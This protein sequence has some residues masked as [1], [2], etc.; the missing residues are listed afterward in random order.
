VSEQLIKEYDELCRLAGARD[1][2]I[3]TE[4]APTSRK[5]ASA[6]KRLDRSRS[7]HAQNR[8]CD[9]RAARS[10]TGLLA[11]RLPR[12]GCNAGLLSRGGYNTSACRLEPT[13]RRSGRTLSCGSAGT[14]TTALVSLVGVP[15]QLRRSNRGTAQWRPRGN[16]PRCY[17]AI[18]GF[19]RAHGMGS[20]STQHHDLG[21]MRDLRWFAAPAPRGRVR[22]GVPATCQA[23]LRATR[24][25]LRPG[26]CLPRRRPCARPAAPCAVSTCL[27]QTGLGRYL[28]QAHLHAARSMWQAM[29]DLMSTITTLAQDGY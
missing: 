1:P 4:P 28:R 24:R 10:R 2:V 26:S 16:S 8:D 11:S 22:C 3:D 5:P 18:P 6:P 19:A 27:S 12:S 14:M 13:G 7:T 29:G 17:Q 23:L 25:G 20:F 15:D 9:E 21:M